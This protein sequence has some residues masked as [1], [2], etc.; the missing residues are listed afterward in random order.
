[1]IT[2]AIAST[3]AAIYAM[4]AAFLADRA[5]ARFDLAISLAS[6]AKEAAAVAEVLAARAIDYALLE[7]NPKR[8]Q[9]VAVIALET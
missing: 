1:V 9:S 2:A 7:T 4:Y 8:V 6:E 3:I 5:I